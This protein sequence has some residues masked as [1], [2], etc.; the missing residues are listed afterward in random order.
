MLGRRLVTVP[1]YFAA[2]FLWLGA[3]PVSLPLALFVDA[4]R[5]N[6]GVL[7]RSSLVL[8]VYLS[9]EVLGV[10]A[11]GGLW[12]WRSVFGIRPERW[13]DL[14]F[15]LEAWW[16]SLLFGATIRSFGLRVEIENEQADLDRGPYLLLLRHASTGDTLLASALVSRPHGLRLRYV[17]KQ[18]LL[19]DP[20]LD[21]VGHRIPNAFVDRFSDDSAH[22]IRR[23]A[24]LARD[25]GPRD[26][27]LIYPEGTRFSEAKRARLLD[28]LDPV[29]DAKRLEYSRSLRYTLPP[30]SGGLLALLEAAP[31]ADVVIC[32]HTGFEG[33]A[34]LAQIWKGALVHRRVRVQFRRVPREEIPTN[35]D[36]R[37][38][39]IDEE[40][41]RVDAWIAGHR[42]AS[43]GV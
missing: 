37:I 16:G 8:T 28:R 10:A 21:I 36:E 20:C 18:E 3:L 40:W 31:A 9:A 4:L 43:G 38:A 13:A 41:Q 11:A 29:D 22:E 42:F 33:A 14:H 35:R 25:L 27:I 2:C 23:V 5:R 30:R 34:S 17:L 15:R 6:R 12:L 19:W 1:G 26:G 24:D 32:A 39:W 7:L